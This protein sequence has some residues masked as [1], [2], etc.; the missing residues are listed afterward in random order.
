MFRP[1][2]LPSLFP[3]RAGLHTARAFPSPAS[4][5]V[6]LAMPRPAPR[7]SPTSLLYALG[8]SVPLLSLWPSGPA[9]CASTPLPAGAD[10]K[11]SFKGPGEPPRSVLDV[12]QLGFGTVCGIC[13]GVFVKKG[14]RAIAFLLGGAFVLLQYL[15]SKSYITIDWKRLTSRYDSVLGTKTP[16]GE[17]RAPTVGGFF[18]GIVDFLSANFQ[19]RATFVAGFVLGIRLG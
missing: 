13:A 14:L 8:L 7:A 11:R 18:N 15:S 1:G 16:T 10:P 6:A 17:V 2:L 4:R 5:C 3:R 12:Y 19:Q 9:Q